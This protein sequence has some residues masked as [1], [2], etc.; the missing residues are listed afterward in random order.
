MRVDQRPVT[1]PER[2]R[3]LDRQPQVVLERL[4]LDPRFNRNAVVV[5]FEGTVGNL[6]R[7][8]RCWTV[9]MRAP[10][11]VAASSP[12]NSPVCHWRVS[13]QSGSRISARR[14][15]LKSFERGLASSR[16]YAV[17]EGGGIPC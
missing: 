17:M 14:L 1:L 11:G 5:G 6:T 15:R 13:N 2:A 10:T 4:A 3:D 16:L 12:L 8:A 7:S 9:R